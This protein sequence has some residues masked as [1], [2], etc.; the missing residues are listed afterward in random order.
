VKGRA[1]ALEEDIGV[2]LS[3]V[4]RNSNIAVQ[5]V[6]GGQNQS[7]QLQRSSKRNDGVYERD[8]QTEHP[9]YA[10]KKAPS[11]A[12]TWGWGSHGLLADLGNSTN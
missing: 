2:S 11:V 4:G 9:W 7:V 3:L 6:E 12:V 1:G 10:C 5:K 8:K